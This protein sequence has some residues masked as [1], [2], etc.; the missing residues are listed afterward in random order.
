MKPYNYGEKRECLVILEKAGLYNGPENNGGGLL[1][2]LS[3]HKEV[4][5]IWKEA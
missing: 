1:D 3:T 4:S 5:I 2:K